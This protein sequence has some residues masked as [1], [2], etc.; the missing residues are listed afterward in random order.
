MTSLIGL[1]E[2]ETSSKFITFFHLFVAEILNGEGGFRKLNFDRPGAFGLQKRLQAGWW[3]HFW[4]GCCGLRIK[5]KEKKPGG[6]GWKVRFPVYVGN[7]FSPGRVRGSV[8]NRPSLSSHITL[9]NGTNLRKREEES[10][11]FHIF[12]LK[13]NLTEIPIGNKEHLRCLFLEETFFFCWNKWNLRNL[14]NRSFPVQSLFFSP[15]QPKRATF[16]L[17]L[18]LP[19]SPI[20]YCHHIP[21]GNLHSGL[22]KKKEKEKLRHFFRTFLSRKRAKSLFSSVQTQPFLLQRDAEETKWW[23]K[24]LAWFVLHLSV[25]GS[26]FLR[27]MAP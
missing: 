13:K 14:W 23:N 22:E 5:K 3:L 7:F 20:C 11:R 6:S 8:R 2:E 17:P 1:R 16:L 15:G 25:S 10:V 9:P 4:G 19:P 24:L 27:V 21:S 18:S 26:C 12:F